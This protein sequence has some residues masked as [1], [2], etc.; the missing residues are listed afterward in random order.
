MIQ[1]ADFF[2]FDIYMF[3]RFRWK[4]FCRVPICNQM[5]L[6]NAL[7]LTFFSFAL[8]LGVLRKEY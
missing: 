3:I 7:V 6:P 5:V 2:F 4:I 1:R 8:V